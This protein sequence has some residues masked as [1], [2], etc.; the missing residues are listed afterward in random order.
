[1]YLTLTVSLLLGMDPIKP[2]SEGDT[3]P[4]PSPFAPSL[5]DLSEEQEKKLDAIVDRFIEADTGKL[6]GSDAKK[7]FE[8][9]KNLGPEAF[10]A[11]VRGL[12]KSA[13]IDHSCPAVLIAKK[14]NAQ[15]IRSSDTELLQYAREN[16]GTGVKESK[17][18][19][20]L[21]DLKQNATTRQNAVRNQPRPNL[22]GGPGK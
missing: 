1:M 2:P 7:A 15:L 9:F 12:N 16:I 18:A 19:G 3:K 8:D 21:R 22:I 10:F 20:V 14:L 17:H 13:S 4:K 11:L 5:P 6:T